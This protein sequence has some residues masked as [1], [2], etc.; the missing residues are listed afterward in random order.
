MRLKT[1]VNFYTASP[2]QRRCEDRGQSFRGNFDAYS[3]SL[4]RMAQW[5]AGTKGTG[6]MLVHGD[7]LEVL[8]FLTKSHAGRVRCAYLDPPYNNGECY[9][10]YY[11]SMGHE[12]WLHAVAARLEQV[13]TLLRDDGSVWISIDDS[14]LHYLKI[15]ADAIFGRNN[16]ITTIVWEHRTT[17]EN[18]KVFSHNHEYLLVYAKD[19]DVWEASRNSLP[20]TND[21][22][23]RYKNMDSDPRGPWQSVSAHVQDG[24]GTP[25][26]YYSF[27][28]PNGQ[29]HKPP[30]GRC[31]IYTKP[32]M[33]KAIA[34][35]NIWFGKDGN[36]VPRLKRF[37]K[38]RKIGL[39][40]ETLWRADNVGTTGDAKKHLLNLFKKE[41]LFDTP[42]PEQLIHRILHIS[43]N[44][45]D[46]V[47]D[48]YLGSGTT[49]AVAHKMGRMYL[50][51]ENGEHIRTHCA[52]RLRQ[53]IRGEA[54]GISQLAGWKGGG[55][56]DYYK[57]RNKKR[58][59]K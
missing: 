26:Q 14:E 21:V 2:Q 42:K 39:T 23:G 10:H 49:A 38:D 30:K 19:I 11:D 15:T 54:G 25:Q 8:K 45:G 56:F 40:P 48:A 27:K 4:Q 36:G 33:L 52:H 31:W 59:A 20:L 6:N 32:K 28:A 1:P 34:K 29:L 35:N 18:R 17:R 16:F 37:L 43:T 41:V 24:H 47:L 3:K 50:G 5:S 55:G 46:L 12:E 51:I 57:F 22:I 53:V 7:N 13:K 44:P 9:K 58:S